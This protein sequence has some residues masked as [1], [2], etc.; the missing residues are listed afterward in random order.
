[1]RKP[2]NWIASTMIALLALGGAAPAA[3]AVERVEGAP[4]SA[5]AI[6][7]DCVAKNNPEDIAMSFIE[8]CRKGSIHREFPGTHYSQRLGDIQRGQSKADKTAW[9]LLND[10]RFMK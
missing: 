4:L 3:G 6:A 5:P 1:M 10:H 9:K 7:K 2:V 8:R